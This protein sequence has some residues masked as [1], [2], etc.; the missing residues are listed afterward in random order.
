[1]YY[2]FEEVNSPSDSFGPSTTKR[3]VGLSLA[4]FVISTTTHSFIVFSPQTFIAGKLFI[5]LLRSLPSARKVY[6]ASM[7]AIT[8]GTNLLATVSTDTL[9]G[10]PSAARTVP[11]SLAQ[12]QYCLLLPIRGKYSRGDTVNG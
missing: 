5:L 9:Q 12:T 6:T 11:L 4:C 7:D 1:M 8:S 3:R 2:S 10:R